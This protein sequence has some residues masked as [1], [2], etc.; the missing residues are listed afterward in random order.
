MKSRTL[1]SRILAV[2]LLMTLVLGLLL[3]AVSADAPEEPTAMVSAGTKHSVYLHTDGSVAAAGNNAVG[4]C[5]VETWKDITKV[6]SGVVTVGITKDQKVVVAG[7]GAGSA[8]TGTWNYIVD[9]AVGENNIIGVQRWGRVLVA[10]DDS[11]G[12]RQAQWS[13]WDIQQAAA[14]ERTIFGLRNDGKVVAEGSDAYDLK[15]AASWK[16][17]TALAAG[18]S[19]VVGLKKD[20]TVVAVG[21]NSEGQCDVS[22][23]QDIIAISAGEAHTVGLKSDGTVVAA[24]RNDDHQCDTSSWEKVTQISA[25]GN[26]TMAMD[27][28]A[29]ILFTGTERND[30]QELIEVVPVELQYCLGSVV[31]FGNYQGK[32]LEWKVIEKGG[33]MVLLISKDILCDRSYGASDA[34]GERPTWRDSELRKWLNEDFLNEAF[35]TAEKKDMVARNLA[36]P[37]KGGYKVE[38]VTDKVTI[39]GLDEVKVYFW[40]EKDR[41]ASGTQNEPA[42]WLLRTYCDDQKLLWYVDENGKLQEKGDYAKMHTAGV[43]PVICVTYRK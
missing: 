39:L 13:W 14:C 25:G 9:A 8:E 38:T 4:Q 18:K 7:L 37:K 12:Q 36:E 11:F 35:T 23:W 26:V 30:Q 6:I 15:T 32:P 41:V 31:T 29:Q 24:G 40:N 19:H 42:P 34:Y 1:I 5:N 33:G 20:G 22:G 10:G 17:I 27:E 28:E 21:D 3:P 43:R 2:L 16:E